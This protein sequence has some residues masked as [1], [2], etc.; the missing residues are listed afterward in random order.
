MIR[1]GASGWS[2]EDW[3]G[4]VYPVPLRARPE[5]WLAHYAQKM[6]AVELTS[7]FH[8]SADE[9][10][11]TSWCREGVALLQGGPFEF[12]LQAPREVTH[13]ALAEGDFERAWAAAARFERVVLDPIADEGLLG[14]VLVRLPASFAPSAD[15]AARLR[16]VLAAFAGRSIALLFDDEAWSASPHARDLLRN[17]DVCLVEDGRD[18][19]PP[20]A[21]HAYLRAQGGDPQVL[22]LRARAHAAMGREVRVILTNAQGGRAVADGVAVLHAL[23]EAT[24][25]PVPRLTAQTRLE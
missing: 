23:G 11:V 22:A 8:T 15:A 9:D 4:P 5:R 12:S 7:T 3:V 25:V 1:V 16:E 24:H 14:A 13:D 20:G 19:S 17:P 21:R 6:R 18:A 2:H 10:L